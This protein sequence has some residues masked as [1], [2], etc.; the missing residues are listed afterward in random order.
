MD[1]L[2]LLEGPGGGFQSSAA[3][4]AGGGSA[5][6]TIASPFAVGRGASAGGNGGLSTNMVLVIGLAVVAVLVVATRR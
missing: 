3:S 4:S 1:P 2:S 6:S 5:E